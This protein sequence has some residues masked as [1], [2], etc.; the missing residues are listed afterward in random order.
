MA[1]SDFHRDQNDDDTTCPREIATLRS[2]VEAPRVGCVGFP[3]YST[4]CLALMGMG[5]AREASVIC[6]H[7][8]VPAKIEHSNGHAS[9]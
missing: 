5:N 8:F 1:S 3:R 7:L 2:N 6:L 9:I 4:D